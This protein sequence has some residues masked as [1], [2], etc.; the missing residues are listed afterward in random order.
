[1]NS[2]SSSSRAHKERKQ[3]R[4]PNRRHKDSSRH[5]NK[6][7]HRRHSDSSDEGKKSRKRHKNEKSPKGSRYYRYSE[8][9]KYGEVSKEYE[10]NEVDEKQD[11]E[12]EKDF[13]FE[14][15]KYELNLIFFRDQDMIKY[16]SDEYNDFWKF[17]RKY[18][19]MQ[20]KAGKK[21]SAIKETLSKELNIPVE[22]DKRHLVNLKL[23]AGLDELLSRIPP[24][25]R[26]TGRWLP[27]KRVIE[28]QNILMLYL[29]FKQ[30]EKFKKFKKLRESQANLPVAQ[31]RYV[32]S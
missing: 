12:E 31:Y 4:S 18:I 5:H 2:K 17:L 15:Y 26:E 27:K 16:G 9:S 8:D 1:M 22:F 13:C 29:D 28:F 10:R 32:Y 3:S 24:R 19:D 7:K 14:K 25:D 21:Y 20:Q 23:E 11:S 30:K 6:H